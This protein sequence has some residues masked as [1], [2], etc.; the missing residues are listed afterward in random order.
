MGSLPARQR[1]TGLNYI[2]M[3]LCDWRNRCDY[4][5]SRKNAAFVLKP[6]FRIFE[7]D[8]VAKAKTV[9]YEIILVFIHLSHDLLNP[10]RITPRVREGGHRV[11]DEKVLSR[12]SR[13]LKLVKQTL[14]LC[15]W[16]AFLDNSR[17]DNPFQQ[18]A[19]IRNEQ[20][21]FQQ[22]LPSWAREL[23]T[24]YLAKLPD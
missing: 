21:Y 1:T 2:V 6:Y 13:V 22:H 12:V 15:D 20:I 19:A 23:L 8:F 7:V 18:V 3:M 5:Y 11:A 4:N 14:L 17:T 16:V 10:A 24:D 9:G